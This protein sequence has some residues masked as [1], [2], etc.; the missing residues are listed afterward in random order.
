[1]S[2]YFNLTTHKVHIHAGD[3]FSTGP[4]AFNII[5][6]FGDPDDLKI[7]HGTRTISGIWE[8]G[9]LS[10]TQTSTS[11]TDWYHELCT[12]QLYVQI[13]NATTFMRGQIEVNG[14]SNNVCD[15]P[16]LI[17]ATA[18]SATKIVLV[19]DKPVISD[20]LPI[21]NLEFPV[22]NLVNVSSFSSSISPLGSGIITLDVSA[23]SGDENGIL[24]I[25]DDLQDQIGNIFDLDNNP[26]IVQN[27]LGGS[28]L[29]I[30]EDS[31]NV[32]IA[33]DSQI[34]E[35]IVPEGV[36]AKL[37]LTSSLENPSIGKTKVTIQ[38]QITATVSEGTSDEVQV[39]FPAGLE[40]TG[41]SAG[42][43][44]VFSL[45]T[46]SSCAASFNTNETVN[47]CV[48]IGVPGVELDF[49]SPVK[50]ILPGEGGSTAFFSTI[51]GFRNIIDYV[52][53]GP[54][55]PGAI[56]NSGP[57]RECAIS[58]EGDLIIFTTHG[59]SFGSFSSSSSGGGSSGGGGRG[60]ISSHLAP[61][62]IL[63]NTCEENSDGIARI[64]AF[65]HPS[66][67]EIVSQIHVDDVLINAHDVTE[68][69]SYR[70]YI[71]HPNPN[72][73]YHVFDVPIPSGTD[74][75]WASVRD[76]ENVKY[77]FSTLVDVPKNSCY[78]V[79]MPYPLK[80]DAQFI[81]P[82]EP[83]EIPTNWQKLESSTELN[84]NMSNSKLNDSPTPVA[85]TMV[86]PEPST[87]K[88]S[89]ECGP[90]TV[91]I[92]GYCQVKSHLNENKSSNKESV[93]SNFFAQLFSWF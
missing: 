26:V 9:D 4:H 67:G 74:S 88:V 40:V 90:G 79:D 1:M 87:S 65:S 6:P 50:I 36:D 78:G 57:L 60:A 43:N 47:S 3:E 76:S 73:D 41:N 32:I 85:S 86:D 48:E 17:S 53:P 42:F 44:G 13:H 15:S 77:R 92:D 2:I 31:P 62:L 25:T 72:Y 52:C 29:E 5:E 75:F 10:D 63:Y 27:A 22:G 33:D 58:Y 81:Q 24:I 28:P 55:N 84:E 23:L 71:D 91:M 68:N 61:N 14:H 64:V 37:D 35:I 69:V 21:T 45:P 70:N 51:D 11:L 38:N 39:I 30:D 54:D 93:F 7:N 16:K 12:E 59:T 20:A 19:F 80:D 82:F 34:E 49:S 66:R 8:V 89:Y 56:S 46:K 18:V 83:L